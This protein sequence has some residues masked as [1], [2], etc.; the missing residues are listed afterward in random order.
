MASGERPAP[1][2]SASEI[3]SV[4]RPGESPDESL[5]ETVFRCLLPPPPWN[6]SLPAALRRSFPEAC[7]RGAVSLP[8]PSWT[9]PTRGAMRPRSAA[10]PAP[11]AAL[12]PPPPPPPV[13]SRPVLVPSDWGGV[14]DERQL[15]AH[16]T[17]A[18]GREAR[19]WLGGRIQVPV[20]AGAPPESTFILLTRARD[21]A[22]FHL[23]PP[24]GE[25]H[26]GARTFPRCIP[27]TRQ[28]SRFASLS[29]RR[30]FSSR[31]FGGGLV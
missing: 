20:P 6:V 26:P 29:L 19:L 12:G 24:S 8:E 7:L 9:R 11:G 30:C 5:G 31:C 13:P 14:L 22:G 18:Q 1:E 27:R 25:P 10:R 2:T 23:H 28:E 16:L 4:R 3:R 21:A 17:Q 15:D